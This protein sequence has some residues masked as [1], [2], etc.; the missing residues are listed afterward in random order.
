MNASYDIE[1]L[2][3]KDSQ[4]KLRTGLKNEYPYGKEFYKC[5]K[6]SCVI[7]YIKT[8]RLRWAEYMKRTDNGEIIYTYNI[9]NYICTLC[10]TTLIINIGNYTKWK[11]KVGRHNLR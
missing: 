3:L 7:K 9:G 2:R 11:K 5:Y 4:E 10:E 6:I 8:A 1:R